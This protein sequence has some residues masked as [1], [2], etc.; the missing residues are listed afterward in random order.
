M[1]FVVKGWFHAS[2]F[3]CGEG[4]LEILMI[5]ESALREN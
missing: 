2:V 1:V 4:K 3:G 5:C